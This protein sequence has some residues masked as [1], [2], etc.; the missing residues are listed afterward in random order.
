M[1]N[2]KIML[3]IAALSITHI[4]QSNA[5]SASLS[6]RQCKTQALEN[7]R[8]IKAAQNEIDAAKAAHKSAEAS[9]Y[10]T[11]DGSVMGI[12]LGKPLGG[13]LNGMIPEYMASGSLNAAQPLYV[14]G[15]IKN[16]KAAVALGVGIREDQKYLAETEVLLN[17]EKAYWQVVQVKEKIKLA[18][19][20]K[21]ML[22]S[23]RKDLQN[24]YDA[25][26]I[27]K[28]DLLKVEVNLNEA[29]LNLN[30]VED[31]LVMAKLNLAQ[32]TGNPGKTDFELSD[33]VIVGINHMEMQSIESVATLRP[34]IKALKKAVEI[35]ELQKKILQ[36]DR[37]PTIALTASGLATGG[38]MVNIKDDSD[39]MA[40]YYGLA[41]ISF[42]IFDW[43]KKAHKVKEQ[44]YKIAAQQQQ[45]D[46][47]IEFIN[48]EVQDSYLTMNQAAKRITLS[49]LSL[50]QA[51]EN[52]K[53]ADDRLAAGT[54]VGKD[55]LE[56][57]AIWQQ[58]YDSL[59]DAK[60]GY[61]I[62]LAVYKK[63]IGE[64]TL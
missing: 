59:I 10:P 28:N 27:Y 57:Q 17:V 51:E 39:F 40:T 7:N 44:K 61:K 55:V 53:L 31:G 15:K 42:P 19:R 13:A 48:L 35:Q 46:E 63:A 21:S 16:G 26:L 11:L 58:A 36:G 41:S 50:K 4:T 43:G 33:S 22:D 30:K 45:L 6:L 1:M 64:R 49:E 23:L 54:I 2:F 24:S 62:S 29:E 20:Y 37:L 34:E 3:A 9:A 8:K 60:V 47:A 5:Q 56:A 32:I 38:K 14:G 12:Y 25:G 18:N 52:L